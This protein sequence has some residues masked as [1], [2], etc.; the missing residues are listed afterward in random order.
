MG[1]GVEPLQ[2]L[3][4]AEYHSSQGLPIQCAAGHNARESALD[5]GEHVGIR[6]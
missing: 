4:I 3:F 6:L 1:N 5:L 2:G